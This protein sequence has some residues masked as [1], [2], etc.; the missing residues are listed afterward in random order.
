MDI[1]YTEIKLFSD[2]EDQ[3]EQ[4]WSITKNVAWVINDKWM[5]PDKGI[6]EFRGEDQHFTFSKVLCWVAID[7]AIKVAELFKKDKKIKKW[8]SLRDRIKKDIFFKGW[9]KKKRAFTQSYN[10]SDLDASVLLMEPYG[11]INANDPK[12]ISTVHAI[13]K[14]LSND[15]LLYR[16]KNEDDFGLPSS[17]FTVCTFWFIDAL[18]KIGERQKA[19]KLFD[20]LLSYS[21]H[22]GLFSEDLDFKTKEL[23]GNFPQA[24]SH[25]ALIETAMN[26]NKTKS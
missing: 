20:K 1:I 8:I 12:Y 9:N 7:R 2:V 21:N 19:K 23:L 11:F 16:Y 5:T 13:E 4:L 18:N 26:L 14:E 25:L 17:S 6:W 10:S 3:H 15:G 22:L 24:Y